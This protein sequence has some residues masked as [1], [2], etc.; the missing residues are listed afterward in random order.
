MRFLANENF[1][2][3]SVRRM[4]DA[5]QDVSA[6]IQESPGAKDLDI[7]NRAVHESRVL[8]TFDRD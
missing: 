1:P 8:L 6:V 5:G 2:L 7:L 3:A 4:Q